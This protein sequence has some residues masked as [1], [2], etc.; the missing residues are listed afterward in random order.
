LQQQTVNLLNF[1]SIENKVFSGQLSFNVLPE[2][3]ASQRTE[4]RIIRQLQTLMG[5]GNPSPS[6]QALQAPVFHGT[7]FSMFVQLNREPSVEVIRSAFASD[8][9][10]VV[11]QDGD[12]PSPVSVA[13]THGIH[14]GRVQPF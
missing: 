7:G 12:G 11:Y 8:G 6:V 4:D 5:T 13:G 1:Q 14:V 9:A 3:D 10:F 2:I